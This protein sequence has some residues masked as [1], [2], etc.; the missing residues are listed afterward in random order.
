MAKKIKNKEMLVAEIHTQQSK[1]RSLE[2]QL[3]A[4]EAKLQR[5]QT[6][7]AAI[8]AKGQRLRQQLERNM[9]L[10]QQNNVSY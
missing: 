9:T 1:L 10:A 6:T 2:L 3:K 4:N 5:L 7:N 8:R